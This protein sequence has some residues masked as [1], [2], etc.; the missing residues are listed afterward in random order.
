MPAFWPSTRAPPP[1]RPCCST[2]RARSSTRRRA[3]TGKSIRSRAGSSTTRKKSGRTCWPSSAKSPAGSADKLADAA[4][5]AITNQRETF[6]VFDRETGRPLHNA[7]VW[8]CRRGDPICRELAS[9]GRESIDS[10]ED[11]AQA[12][13]LF[14]RLEAQMADPRAARDSPDSSLAA[15]HSSARSTPTS[16]TG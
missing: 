5:L 10:A 3:S 9:A 14:L 7:I 12:R 2:P 13:H 11:R 16:S 6:V 4:G 8:Q 15:T 1:P